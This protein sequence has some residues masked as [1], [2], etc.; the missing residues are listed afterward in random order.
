MDVAI[1]CMSSR[2]V[3]EGARLLTKERVVQGL[4]KVGG[5]DRMLTP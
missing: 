4:H 5:V 2:S 1:P 3:R